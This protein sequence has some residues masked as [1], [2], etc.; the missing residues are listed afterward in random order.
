MIEISRSARRFAGPV[1]LGLIG[2]VAG[3]REPV[4]VVQAAPL[5]T[6]SA[7]RATSVVKSAVAGYSVDAMTVE[8]RYWNS[9]SWTLETDGYTTW[10]HAPPVGSAAL[11][12]FE[13]LPRNVAGYTNQPIELPT[14]QCAV[15][16]PGVQ[17]TPPWYADGALPSYGGCIRNPGDG[18]TTS[19]RNIAMR[20]RARVTASKG[21]TLRVR[22]AVDF[23]G[24]VLIVDGQVVDQK[25]NDPFWNGFFDI[26]NGD[27]AADGLS[28]VPLIETDTSTVLTAAF[29][30]SANST[31]LIEVIGFENGSDFGASAQFND[32]SGWIDAVSMAPSYRVPL[33]VSIGAGGG[34][35][36]SVPT[37]INC[38]ATCTASFAWATMPALTAT[39]AE[40]F[41][42][43]GW[44]G[45]CSAM[46]PC[47]PFL[48]T[49]KSVTATFTRVQ[50]PL[51][52]MLAG[53]GSGTVTSADHVIN[54]GS[55]CLAGFP[56]GGTVTL[57]AAS[58][59]NSVFA[60]WSGGG[61]SG[62]GTCLVPMNQ[63]QVVTATFQ[64]D[65]FALRVANVG[66][67][68]GVVTSSPAGITCD[69]QCEWSFAFGSTVVLTAAPALGSDFTGWSGAGCSGTATCTVT[70]S[71]AQ[72]V[73]A[74]FNVTPPPPPPPST[75]EATPSVLWP[76]DHKMV[77]IAIKPLAGF[78]LKS[79][80]SSEPDDAPDG[81]APGD[82]ASGDGAT[83][84]DMQGWV[85]DQASFSGRLRAERDGRG[86]GRT[87][88]FVYE[89]G[90]ATAVCSVFV[91]RDRSK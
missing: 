73:T 62:T 25:W 22:W 40:Y 38:G 4:G 47:A 79:V 90:A 28:Y 57:T 89:S 59:A 5:G 32:G 1:V 34:V 88:S 68:A 19:H 11:L 60:G 18:S 54:C 86:K 80:T 66:T 49:P 12:T 85:L 45:V 3:C 15:I 61:C 77:A 91:P 84:N 70:M 74:T 42:F 46:A 64:P 6:E 87:Y 29:R 69:A 23:V 37:G 21:A 51:Q 9:G 58:G 48:E 43:S 27:L 63:A 17:G 31:H 75:C 41:V 35:V 72:A 71:Q 2:L 56:V 50:W 78:T 7:V 67:G 76:A 20:Y 26:D 65:R 82:D 52:V 81:G 83:V 55:A 13:S 53:T 24:G 16:A 10:T 33:S 39:P 14:L 36:T 8:T 30:V 44:S